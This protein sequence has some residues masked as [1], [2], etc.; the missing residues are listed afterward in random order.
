MP[1]RSRGMLGQDVVLQDVPPCLL[2]TGALTDS[3]IQAVFHNYSELYRAAGNPD[4]T[5]ESACSYRA[6]GL[7]KLKVRQHRSRVAQRL[8]VPKRT[9]HLFARCGLAGRT[10]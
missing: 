2:L 3:K 4:T 8:N 9:P 7:Q 1:V 5:K 6:D 10:F